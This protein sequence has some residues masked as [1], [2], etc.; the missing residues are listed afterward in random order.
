MMKNY[1]NNSFDYVSMVD[2]YD[3]LPFW[4]APFGIKLLSLVDYRPNIAALDIGFGT[5]FPLTELAMRLGE[6]SIVYGIDPWRDTFSRVEQ[7]ITAYGITNI[8]LIEGKAELIP[9]GN[10]STDLIVSNNGINNVE[11]MDKVFAECSRIIKPG[12]Q[13][14]FTMNLDTSMVEFYSVFKEVLEEMQMNREINMMY[15]HIYQ[16]RRPVDEVLALVK[17]HGFAVKDL[18]YDQFDYRFASGTAMLNHYFIRLAFMD[19]WKKLL[20][21]RGIYDVFDKIEIRLNNLAD[22]FGSI[23]LSIPF[24]AINSCYI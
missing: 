1:L 14:V 24:V 12:G 21:E 23:T 9:L 2:V 15:Q 4:S 6:G 22:Q 17:K 3:E 11:D 10:N 18:R 5:G 16:K 8:T 13:F 7:K 19:S 20:P